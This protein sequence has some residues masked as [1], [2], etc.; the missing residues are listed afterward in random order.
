MVWNDVGNAGFGCFGDIYPEVGVTGNTRDRSGEQH[1]LC[2]QCVGNP[3]PTIRQV[4]LSTSP[5][6]PQAARLGPLHRE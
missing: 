5:V 1:D 4:R 6:F 3:G 2:G